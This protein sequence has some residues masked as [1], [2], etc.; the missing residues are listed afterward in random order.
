ML[1]ALSKNL[2]SPK[3]MDFKTRLRQKAD[4]AQAS[5]KGKALV[6]ISAKT[7]VTIGLVLSNESKGRHEKSFLSQTV[8][9]PVLHQ[10]QTPV[11]KRPF[12]LQIQPG[13]SLRCF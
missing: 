9:N 3:L 2:A 7:K 11:N 5:H 4:E 1:E 13:A 10:V 6:L 8:Y 12:H